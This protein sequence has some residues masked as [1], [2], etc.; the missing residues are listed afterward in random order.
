MQWPPP[1][2]LIITPSPVL[3]SWA[4]S[5]AVMTFIRIVPLRDFLTSPIDTSRATL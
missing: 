2:P 5:L 1:E 4:A 3:T